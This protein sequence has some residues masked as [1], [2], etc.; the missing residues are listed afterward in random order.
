[1]SIG[2][3]LGNVGFLGMPVLASVFPGNPIVLVYSSINVM[4]MNLIVFTLGT[5]MITNDKKYISIK[6]MILN[7]TTIAILIA[8]PIFISGIHFPGEIE[9]AIALLGKMVT[10]VCMLIC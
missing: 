7:P 8:L 4:S 1:M 9:N 2:G 6:G 5:Y 3:V 10:P